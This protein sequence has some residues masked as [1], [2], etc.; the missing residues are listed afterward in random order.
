MAGRTI[1]NCS[2]DTLAALVNACDEGLLAFD[3]SG[4]IV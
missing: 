2:A 1:A 4:T 3:V